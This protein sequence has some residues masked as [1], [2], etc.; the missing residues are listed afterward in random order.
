MNLRKLFN[1]TETKVNKMVVRYRS[2]IVLHMED[3]RDIVASQ[4]INKANKPL[5]AWKDFLHWYHGRTGS[6]TFI[7]RNASGTK[8]T[9]VNRHDIVNYTVKTDSQLVPA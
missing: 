5:S 9:S 3:G 4:H 1:R 6:N 8:Y 7:I 2:T